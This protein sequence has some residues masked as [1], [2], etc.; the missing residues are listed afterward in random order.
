MT[1]WRGP[2]GLVLAACVGGGWLCAMVAVS[3]QDAQVS[4]QGAALLNTLGGALI[5]GVV[6][7]LGSGPRPDGRTER[8]STMSTDTPDRPEPRDPATN[9]DRDLTTQPQDPD[10]QPGTTPDE[11]EDVEST[12]PAP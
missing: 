3:F 4:T 9:P 2:T 6:G 8:G 5:G 12:R 11:D 1:D 10:A 7:W